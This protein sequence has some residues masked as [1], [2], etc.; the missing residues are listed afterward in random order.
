M[1]S[2]TLLYIFFHETF[3]F[4]EHAL[5][6]Y[7]EDTLCETVCVHLASRI[8]ALTLVNSEYSLY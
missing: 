7:R 6:V 1:L 5:V 8:G 2:M 3:S 4:R